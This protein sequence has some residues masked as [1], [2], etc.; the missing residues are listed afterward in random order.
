MAK[1]HSSSVVDRKAEI[2]KDVQIGPLCYVE[3]GAVIGPGCVLDSHVT[4]KKGATVGARNFFGQGSV[5]GGD[6]QDRKWHGE[7]TFLKI[8]DDNHFREYVTIHRANNE[9]GSTIVGDRNYLM[10]YVHLGHNCHIMNEQFDSW[11]KASH[12]GFAACVDCHLPQDFIPKYLAKADNG[13]WHSKGFT[14]MDFHEP[15]LIKP[16]NSQILQDNC[17]RCHGDFVHNIV[18]GSTTELDAVRCV[19]CHAS[20]GHGARW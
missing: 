10:S 13:F 2:A 4:V 16:R 12:H 20:V 1:V 19:H 17:L 7:P 8:G 18:A 3:A 15:I 9:G 6:P 14:F 11:T 5:I